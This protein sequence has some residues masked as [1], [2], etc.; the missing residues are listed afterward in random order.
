[1]V[2]MLICFSSFTTHQHD[3]GFVEACMGWRWFREV[4]NCAGCTTS[5]I[6]GTIPP[7]DLG[8]PRVFDH[9]MRSSFP[10]RRRRGG[11][12]AARGNRHEHLD[13]GLLLSVDQLAVVVELLRGGVVHQQREDLEGQPFLQVH[14]P[15]TVFG[16]M[17]TVG[18]VET[19]PERMPD[20]E[21]QDPVLEVEL[22]EP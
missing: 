20:V 17:P 14:E 12:L 7:H 10:F 16:G 22:P 13:V 15:P 2:Q 1:M 9:R 4:D 6:I 8:V 18:L 3:Y 21:R 19:N 11:E 5:S